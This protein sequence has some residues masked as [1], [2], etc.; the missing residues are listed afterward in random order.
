MDATVTRVMEGDAS[1]DELIAYVTQTGGQEEKRL[2]A[3]GR[4][5]EDL[6]MLDEMAHVAC[7]LVG[8]FPRRRTSLKVQPPPGS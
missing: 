1:R 6:E 5:K 7:D 8:Q 4:K 3:Q 2:L